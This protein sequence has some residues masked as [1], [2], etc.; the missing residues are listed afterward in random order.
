MNITRSAAPGYTQTNPTQIATDGVREA[1][2]RLNDN[3]SKVAQTQKT[4]SSGDR[5]SGVGS[6]VSTL[7]EQQQMLREVSANSNS[8]R[9]ANQMVGTIIDVKV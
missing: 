6:V 7:A 9:T 3:I 2:Q 5:P 8:L 1:M 4:D